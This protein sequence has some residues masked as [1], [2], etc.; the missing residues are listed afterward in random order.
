MNIAIPPCAGSAR[1]IFMKTGKKFYES[2][3]SQRTK[4]V[5]KIRYV[6]ACVGKFFSS[7]IGVQTEDW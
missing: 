2:C 7:L 4:K 1:K 6:L 3:N 5:I